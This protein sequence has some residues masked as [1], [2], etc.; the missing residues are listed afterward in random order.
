MCKLTLTQTNIH[1]H[2]YT[3]GVVGD[4]E[5]FKLRRSSLGAPPPA[6]HLVDGDSSTQLLDPNEVSK[7]KSDDSVPACKQRER[8]CVWVCDVFV[9]LCQCA[10]GIAN[11][12]SL[13]C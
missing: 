3:L 6:I 1:T 9:C 5:E 2:V 8:E 4:S 12:F 11:W 7:S 10:T 13:I